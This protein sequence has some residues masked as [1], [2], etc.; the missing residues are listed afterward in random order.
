VFDRAVAV[1][2]EENG[3]RVGD[4][5]A[6]PVS[7]DEDSVATGDGPPA[8]YDAL[9]DALVTL[10]RAAHDTVERREESV[11]V[12]RA[13]FDPAAARTLDV[14]EGPKFGKLADGQPVTVDGETI[15]PE[16]VQRRDRE[17]FPI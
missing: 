3:N 16:T 7:D 2:T 13:T 15:H 17:T 6:F 11:V 9:V 1:V 8:A 5:A 4:R 14:P 10:L 12:E